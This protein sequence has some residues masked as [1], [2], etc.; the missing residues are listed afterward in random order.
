MNQ[1]IFNA[2]IAVVIAGAGWYLKTVWDAIAGQKAD[3]LR[4]WDAA[5]AQKAEIIAIERGMYVSFVTKADYRQDINEI[6][7]MLKIISDKLDRKA[8][9]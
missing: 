6:K 3:I 4:L 1:E 7:E 2:A 8:D 5:T 9:K